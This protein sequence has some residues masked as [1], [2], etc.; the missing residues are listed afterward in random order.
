MENLEIVLFFMIDYSKCDDNCLQSYA[1]EGDRLAE[2]AL[3][4][5]YMRLVRI[6]SRPLFLA[7]GDHE[8]LIQEGMFGL[9]S[10]VRQ[11][12][13]SH[14]TSFK[15][16]A[17]LCI[18]NRLLT[19][20][21]SASSAKHIP[22]NDG[23]SLEALLSDETRTGISYADFF[24]ISPEEQVLARENERYTQEFFLSFFDRLS[25]LETQVLQL[26]L[27]GLSYREI[28]LVCNKDEKAV[29][30]AIQRIRGKLAQSIKSGDISLS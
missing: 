19:A 23:V 13:P 27:K 12:D 15:T 21:R 8:D 25:K 30:N 6:C 11:Y 20:I 26:Y 9:I 24:Q 3:V 22:L 14:N 18:K 10:A 1:A 5:R 28:S 29:D 2:E 16:F 4:S 17:E 7:G